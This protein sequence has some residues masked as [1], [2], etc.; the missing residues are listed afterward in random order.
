MST[1]YINK[2]LECIILFI[3]LYLTFHRIHKYLALEHNIPKKQ[4]TNY[5]LKRFLGTRV[6]LVFLIIFSLCQD[7]LENY[8]VLESMHFL[9]K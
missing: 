8:L 3:Q 6:K 5:Q 2:I 1:L 7:F 9:V 4:N